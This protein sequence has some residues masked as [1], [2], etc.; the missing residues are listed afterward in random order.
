MFGYD[1]LD[2][3]PKG[4]NLLDRELEVSGLESHG[5]LD[6]FDGGTSRQ[7]A[8]QRKVTRRTNKY[9]KKNYKFEGEELDR[10]YNYAKR[11]REIKK[12]NLERDLR[13]QEAT[14]Q[15]AWN[16]GMAIR[17]YEHSR[18]TAAYQ[19]SVAQATA[20]KTFNSVANDFANLQQDRTMMEQQLDLEFDKNET[21]LNY[22]A[23]AHGL[24]L[25]KKSARSSAAGDLRKSSLDALKAKGSTASRGQAGRTS[26]KSLNAIHM[27]ANMAENDIVN[28]L[29][30]NLE[31]VDMEL[32]VAKQQNAMDNL[33]L[34]LSENNLVASDQLTRSQIKMQRAQADLDAE[35]SIMLK[36]EIAPPLPTPLTMPRPKFQKIYKPKQ[37]PKPMKHVA[38]QASVGAAIFNNALNLATTAV[39]L[40]MKPPFG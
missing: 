3:N 28:E 2:F 31:Q 17:D 7:N 36:P 11:T 30:N 12:E 38:Y 8:Y 6:W 26:A 18:N 13:Y 19:Q 5:I 1:N 37:G 10:Q 34:S 22:T 40:G 35:A 15:Q 23:Q 21:L 33:A 39:T 9:N 24:M 32:L 14:R 4:D 16:Y 27:E 25:K 20:Q 29:M